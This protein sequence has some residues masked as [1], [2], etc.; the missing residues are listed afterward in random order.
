MI[1]QFLESYKSVFSPSYY[2][3]DSGYDVEYVYEY[4]INKY[5][6]VAIIA[7]NPGGSFA[8]PEGLDENFNSIC[9]AGCKLVYWSKDKNYLKFRCPHAIDRCDCPYDMNWCSSS[10]Y[11]YT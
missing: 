6:A 2:A 4:I 9:S 1:D 3:M 8:P 7:Y 10:N 11:G 5:D